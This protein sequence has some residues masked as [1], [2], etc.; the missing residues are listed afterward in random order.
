MPIIFSTHTKRNLRKLLDLICIFTTVS[1]MGILLTNP[2]IK[3]IKL[4]TPNMYSS[5]FIR[6]CNYNK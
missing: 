3:G 2:Y 6:C 4:S 5:H 1:V